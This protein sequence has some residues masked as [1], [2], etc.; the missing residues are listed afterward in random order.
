MLFAQTI[1]VLSCSV[2]IHD[3]IA[4]LN[5]RLDNNEEICAAVRINTDM[6]KGVVFRGAIVGDIELDQSTYLLYMPSRTKRLYL[7]CQGYLPTTIDLSQYEDS[8]KGLIGGKTYKIILDIPKEEK[9][10]SKYGK[11]SKILQFVSNIPLE[12]V[13]VNGIEWSIKENTSKRIVPYGKYNYE[14]Y[15]NGNNV[16]KG[17]VEVKESLGSETVRIV[18]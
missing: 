3:S 10:E 1:G 16:K 2:D 6:L 7:Y 15:A 8:S 17:E 12:K 13:V 18:F 14:I 9:N 4:V 11:G 5:P